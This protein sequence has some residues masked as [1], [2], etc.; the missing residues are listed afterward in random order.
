MAAAL[1]SAAH[2]L[3]TSPLCRDAPCSPSSLPSCLVGDASPL[4]P[5]PSCQSSE[6]TLGTIKALE[7][8]LDRQRADVATA[9]TTAALADA[10]ASALSAEVARLQRRFHTGFG[11]PLASPS[12][13]GQF[14]LY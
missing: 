8:R 14:R 1:L 7:A 10:R 11:S 6:A 3:H 2:H 5:P 13:G 4:T 12:R 9:G